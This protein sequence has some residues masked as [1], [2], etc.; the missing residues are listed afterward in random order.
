MD[1]VTTTK[2]LRAIL[3]ENLNRAVKT[4]PEASLKECMY[5][6]EVNFI[7]SAFE[8]I[9]GDQPESDLWHDFACSVHGELH[10]DFDYDN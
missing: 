5:L 7:K 10:K 9:M 1:C 8:A 4:M 2:K 6:A 3:N